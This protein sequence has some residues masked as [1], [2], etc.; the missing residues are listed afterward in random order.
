MDQLEELTAGLVKKTRRAT[1][2]LRALVSEPTASAAVLVELAE[3]HQDLAEAF[4]QF[5][6]GLEGLRHRRRP[7]GLPLAPL[8][9]LVAAWSEDG[10]RARELLGDRLPMALPMM[11]LASQLTRAVAIL[12]A[13]RN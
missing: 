12:Q 9:E 11:A 3:S 4:H 1:L 8:A 13:A 10:P 2:A 6:L 7:G 5:A